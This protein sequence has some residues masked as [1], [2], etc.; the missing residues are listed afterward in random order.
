MTTVTSGVPALHHFSHPWPTGYG[1]AAARLIR[2]LAEAGGET[3]W[4]PIAFDEHAPL[5]PDAFPAPELLGSFERRSDR[6]I[7]VVAHC[8][9]ELLPALQECRPAGTALVI[10]TVWEALKVQDH[11]PELLNSADAVVVPTVWNAEAFRA[12]GVRVPIEVVPHAR[13][14]FC[15][16]TAWLGESG[17]GLSDEFVVHSIAAWTVRKD[18]ST[19]VAAFARAFGPGDR[20]R[21]ILKTDQVIDRELDAPPGPERLR[22]LSSWTVAG[23]LHR[24]QPAPTVDLVH[25][26]LSSAQVAGLHHRSDCWLSLPHAEGWDLGAFD[27]AVAGVPVITVGHGGP[28]EYLGDDYAWLVS[29]ELVPFKGLP[30]GVWVQPDIDAAASALRLV[31]SDPGGARAAAA[32]LAT[33]LHARHA[34]ERI[35]R[36]FVAALARAGIG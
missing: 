25:G 23:I 26:N 8:V 22:R 20:S 4:A 32:E 27:A 5:L 19:T 17:L 11:W 16:D 13:S 33:R 12:A 15:P 7:A 21:L 6:P 30:G 3:T 36:E 2:S 9:P 34:P 29:G 24:H 14:N 28:L 35:A 1:V 18:P 31:A 10:C